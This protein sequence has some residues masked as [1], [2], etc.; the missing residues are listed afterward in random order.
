MGFTHQLGNRVIT[1]S[2]RAI[3]NEDRYSLWKEKVKN[4]NKISY[5]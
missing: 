5:K 3:T 4:K 1:K 2:T